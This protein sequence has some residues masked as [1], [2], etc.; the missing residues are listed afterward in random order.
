V[1]FLSRLLLGN[2]SLPA[3]VRAGLEAEGLLLAEEGLPGR[4]RY[5]R[6]RAPGRRFSGKVTGERLGLGISARRLAVYCRSGRAKLIDSPFDSPRF[7]ALEPRL[8]GT[9]VVAFRIDYDR[10]AEPGVSGVITISATTASAPQIVEEL[11]ARLGR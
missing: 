3:A 5:E 11:N 10:M 6:F 1:G 4:I 8:E 7:S 2:G 9:D